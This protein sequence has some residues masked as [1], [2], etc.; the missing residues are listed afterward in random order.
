M[1]AEL[2]Y[3]GTGRV[4]RGTAA[5]L[6]VT[7]T[8]D[9][10]LTTP[11]GTLT[12]SVA[13]RFSGDVIASGTPSTPSK[14]VLSAALTPTQTAL[15]RQCVVTWAGLVFDGGAPLEFTTP[16]EIVGQWLFTLREA[17]EFASQGK[18]VFADLSVYTDA[19]ILAGRDRVTAAFESIL[20]FPVGLQYR[21]HVV[22]GD[23]DQPLWLDAGHVGA[24]RHV[25][26]FNQGY[27]WVAF[28]ETALGKLVAS[29]GGKIYS[30]YAWPFYAGNRNVR[31]GVEQGIDPI[32]ADLRGAAL[33]ALH[34][35]T[36]QNDFGR[37]AM[38]V[39]NQLG[40]ITLSTA[41]RNPNSPT[42]IPDVDA[43]LV[44]YRRVKVAIS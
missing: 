11:T 27:S 3:A 35:T 8:L 2:E 14:G 30:P 39:A 1:T 44:R 7:C 42:G 9:G 32:P 16:A 43:V 23:A 26:A 25:T 24:I 28:D 6:Q 36:T 19:E 34:D 33:I 31:I 41:N 13:D 18:K 17:R 20:N 29:P 10:A 4:L 22:D 12:Y 38:S 37:R 15:V 40:N 21:E 5:D